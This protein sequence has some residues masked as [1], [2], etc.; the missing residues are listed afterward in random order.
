[1]NKILIIGNDTPLTKDLLEKKSSLLIIGNNVPSINNCIEMLTVNM[2]IAFEKLGLDVKTMTC[3]QA[4]YNEFA[5]FPEVDFVMLI[6]YHNKDIIP[7]CGV[8]KYKT[9][10]K[11]MFS[12]IECAFPFLDYAFCFNNIT[13][14][15][16]SMF[17][18]L[19]ANKELLKPTS[20]T[21]KTV[22]IDHY[23]RPYLLTPKEWTLQ[24]ED[25][26]EE[27]V[28]FGY[29]F[30][31][32]LRF[33]EEEKTI[34]PYEIPIHYSNYANYLEATKE[35]ETFVVTH[36]ESYSYGVIDM[37]C[38]GTRVCTPPGFLP[39]CMV[40]RLNIPTFSKK[41]ELISIIRN[42]LES[43]WNESSLK[44]TD[45]NEIARIINEKLN[46]WKAVSNTFIK[47]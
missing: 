32:L 21:P 39:K 12:F 11:K 19:P 6:I 4:F 41:E 7:K 17:I 35:I 25:W 14:N 13:L 29:K 2:K 5:E 27:L 26:L 34:K 44:C 30:Y 3:A 20:K 31:R 22:L 46:E 23:W 42:P 8:I 45:Y 36:K 38:R 18:N 40:E 24:I 15:D 16:H 28:D 10:C 1:M 37:A 9:K 47:I 43:Y 33:E